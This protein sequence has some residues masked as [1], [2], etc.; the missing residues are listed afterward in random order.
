M[1]PLPGGLTN[2][3]YI[4]SDGLRSAV[5]RLQHPKPASL[6]ISRARESSIL[7]AL[8]HHAP[9]IAPK[10]YFEDAQQRFAVF[11]HLQGRTWHA[12]D[13]SDARQRARLL[14]AIRTYQAVPIALPPRN[15]A[16]YLQHY[17]QQWQRQ[18]P[19]QAKLYTAPW[20]RFILRLK[21]FEQSGY[22]AVLVHHDLN[23]ANIMD[24]DQGLKILDW[25]YAAAGIAE[26]DTLGVAH[27]HPLKHPKT[28][29][30]S[31]GENAEGI[32]GSLTEM[33]CLRREA[34]TQQLCFWMDALWWAIR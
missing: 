17:W 5:L 20:K 15:Y 9:D 27:C 10:L 30:S 23:P 2:R 25:E 24:T 13:F 22:P 3:S 31:A 8:N 14:R 29:L 16:G 26:I 32:L 1:Q 34:L 18:A 4:V 6:G 7:Q 33:K 12:R 28:T 19:R 21:R 11:E